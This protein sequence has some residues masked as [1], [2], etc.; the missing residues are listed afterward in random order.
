MFPGH[1]EYVTE[2]AYGVVERFRDLGGRLVFLSANNFF[3]RVDRDGDAISRIRQWRD[4]GRPESAL[5]GVQYRANDD[6]RAR[7]PFTVLGVEL[8]PWLFEG[9]GLRNGDLLGKVVGGYGIEIDATTASSPEGTVV[10]AR[11]EGLYGPGFDAEMTY[12]ETPA[13]A[14]VFSA[15]TL[16][17]TSSSRTWPVSRMLQNLWR[18]MLEDVPPPPAAA[19]P[20]RRS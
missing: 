7:Q 19:I 1:S 4:L 15:G 18:H 20:S 12:Y 11:I 2:H 14:R 16:D 9:T 17:F 10:L 5:L 13:G 6:G 8:A 3:W